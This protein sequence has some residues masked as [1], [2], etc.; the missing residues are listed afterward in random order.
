M[1]DLYKY[2]HYTVSDFIDDDYFIQWINKPDSDSNDFW[3][4][5]LNKYPEKRN[6]I[7]EAKCI[8]QGIRFNRY[9]VKEEF[10]GEDWVRIK[11]TI[12][13]TVHK[14]RILYHSQWS[15]IAAIV[16]FVILASIGLVQ[17]QNK[18]HPYN[19]YKTD[20]GQKKVIILPDNSKVIL[21]ANSLLKIEKDWKRNSVRQVWL[22]GEAFFEVNKLYG[23]DTNDFKKFIVH[24]NKTNI[25]VIGTR[26]NVNSRHQK[27]R[28]VLN[29]GKILVINDTKQVAME[30]REMIEVEEKTKEFKKRIV[31]PAIYSAWKENQ[32]IFQGTLVTEILQTIEDNYGYEIIIETNKISN[33]K[34]T[35]SADADRIDILLDK[36]SILYDLEIKKNESTIIIN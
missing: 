23:D 4:S 9:I 5:F 24:A 35:G 10:I 31:D 16:T 20:F 3:L 29:E 25:E 22:R 27:T 1:K 13:N 2:Y 11:Q 26:F 17:L 7:E 32:L 12:N 36:L 15:K 30:P 28:I 19:E 18:F 14:Q 6:E 34:Y 33:K 21:N 8:I